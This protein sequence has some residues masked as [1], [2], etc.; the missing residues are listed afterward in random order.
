MVELTGIG[1]RGRQLTYRDCQIDK[2]DTNVAEALE[3]SSST[4]LPGYLCIRRTG[5]REFVRRAA[6]NPLETCVQNA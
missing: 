3:R 5:V 4:G 1:G 2:I 6:D